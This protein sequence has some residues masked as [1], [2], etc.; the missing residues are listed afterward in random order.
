MKVE[1]AE[2]AD[3]AG[4][5]AAG[6]SACPSCDAALVGDFCH[7]CGEKRPGARDLTLRHFVA[8]AAQEFTSVEHSKIFRTLRALLLR[9]G[10]LSV[11]WVAGRRN[12]YLKPLNLCLIILA[13]HV[14]VYST[15]QV[16]TFDFGQ[17]VETERQWAAAS[18]RPNRSVY[19]RSIQRAMSARGLSREA[20]LE[21]I[22]ERWSRNV[23]FFQLPLILAYAVLLQ[24]FY[25]FSRRHFVEHVVFSLHFIAFTAL[26]VILMWPVYYAVG[27]GPTSAGLWVAGAKFL[28]DITYLFLAARAFYRDGVGWALVK[29]PLMFAAY[30]FIYVTTYLVALF[31]AIFSVTR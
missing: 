21:Q 28:L 15:K 6:E 4:A 16:S 13:L 22:S 25:L 18:G 24:L 19:D 1:A 27:I 29:A 26:T 31:A 11:E 23:S 2:A 9:P 20:V 12:L 14:F 30:F 17:I 10:F 5:T 7:R 8:E 3:V